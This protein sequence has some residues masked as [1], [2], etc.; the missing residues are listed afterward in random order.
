MTNYNKDKVDEIVLALLCL[1]AMD[2]GEWV[3][4]YKTWLQSQAEYRLADS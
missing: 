1:N 3:S 2:F 4:V